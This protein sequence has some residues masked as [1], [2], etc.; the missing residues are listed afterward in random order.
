MSTLQAVLFAL[1]TTI[2]GNFINAPNVLIFTGVTP[3]AGGL[4]TGLV[5]GDPMTGLVA[6]GFIQVAYLGWV[7]AGGALPSNMF[8]A[9]YFGTALTIM[10]GADPTTAPAFAIPIGLLGILVHQAQ[11]TIN[12][13]FVHQGDK[14]AEKGNTKGIVLMQTVAPLILNLILYGVPAFLLIQFGSDIVE[15]TFQQI[16]GWLVDGLSFTG[17]MMPALGIAMLLYY[18]GKKYVLP[19]FFLGFFMVVYLNLGLN[20][21]AIFGILIALVYY[22]QKTREGALNNG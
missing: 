14:F 3:L 10:A 19:F 6:G 9:G 11:M 21:M 8:L 5:L 18:M 7:S 16:P 4:I 17:A 20:A 22:L 15:T 13:F 2:W 1:V 12:A